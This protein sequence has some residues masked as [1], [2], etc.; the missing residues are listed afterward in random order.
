[1]LVDSPDLLLAIPPLFSIEG[2]QGGGGAK[3]VFLLRQSPLG[4]QEPQGR[5][6]GTQALT[7]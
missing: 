5:Y 7:L 2:A 3:I 4:A 1:M 6:W